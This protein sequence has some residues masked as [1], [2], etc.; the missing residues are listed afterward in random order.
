MALSNKQLQDRIESIEDKLNDIQVALNQLATR[1]QLKAIL[2][3]RQSEIIQ[4][5]QD[6]EQVELTGSGPVLENHR[7]DAFAHTELDSRYYPQT[8]FIST[9][10]GASDA[11]KP[12]VL[13]S[14]GVL[15]SS[16]AG[17]VDLSSYA[18]VSGGADTRIA[19]FTGANTIEADSDFTWNSGTNTLTVGSTTLDSSGNLDSVER[20][21]FTDEI[22]Y[23]T[24]SGIETVDWNTGQKQGMVLAGD[25]TLS[26]TDPPGVGNY[27]LRV[28][29]DAAGSHEI[30]WPSNVAWSGGVPPV[31]TTTASGIDILSLYWEGTTYYG[32]ASLNFA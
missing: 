27:L 13:N 24:V 8:S 11:G 9:S 28:E 4:L 21:T 1:T 7:V 2:N 32:V 18:T 22:N 5:R 19:Y 12:V 14:S 3:V 20:V 25:V 6:L 15:D 10:A 30:T 26:F 17:G 29:Q 23:G 31:L 16:I